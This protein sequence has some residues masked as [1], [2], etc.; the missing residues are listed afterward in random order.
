MGSV[1]GKALERLQALRG[2]AD[3]LPPQTMVWQQVEAQARHHFQRA[4][5]GEIR[6]PLLEA[7]VL[8]A[9]GIGEATDVVGKEMYSFQDRGRRSC[10]MRPEGTAS[11]VRAAIQH[12]LLSQGPQRL[13]YMGPMFR[14]ERPQAGR[15]RQFHQIGLELL[16]V[17]DERSDVDAI[18]LAWDLLADL[19]VQGLQL[20]INTLGTPE[21]RRCYRE[22]LVGWL[23]RRAHQLDPDSQQ[24]L[25]TNP[26]RIL[27]SKNKDT[28]HL[29]SAAPQLLETLGKGSRERFD[30]V[31]QLLQALAI[32]FVLQPRLVRGLD[33]YT[34]TAFEI[35]CDQLGAQATVCGGGRYDG[36]AAML[37]G[38]PTAGM[39]WAMGVER[40]VLLLGQQSKPSP[41][42]VVV[43]NRG[44]AAQVSALVLTRQLRRANLHV[45]L[46]LSGAAFARQFKRADRTGGRLAVIIGEQ[47][48][49]AGVV[50]LKWLHQ[51]P[52]LRGSGLA[53]G[54]EWTVAAVDA[55]GTVA[56]LLSGEPRSRSQAEPTP[57]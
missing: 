51:A 29:L 48:A 53:M 31:C 17:A 23:E 44:D 52:L 34:H 8:F 21:D 57:V 16:G 18:A 4:G 26:L 27:D 37:G 15:Q 6:T 49:Q 3:L 10:T 42:Q 55:S 22:Q 45:E 11:V 36:L 40:L 47:E 25:A 20:Q 9:R 39:G 2:M 35:T 7:T 5:V 46:D 32:P 28:Q 56:R 38:P 43:L 13:W 30:R 12:G 14:Y 19:G 33:Y 50:K 41:P 1:S 54:E 24:R